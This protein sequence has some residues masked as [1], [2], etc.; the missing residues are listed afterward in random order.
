MPPAEPQAPP[1]SRRNLRRSSVDDDGSVGQADAEVRVTSAGSRMICP[2]RD[3]PR[4]LRADAA[5]VT[6]I[7]GNAIPVSDLPCSP[8]MEGSGRSAEGDLKEG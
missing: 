6:D 7:S 2:V 4:A 5:E 3:L 8:A 1:G